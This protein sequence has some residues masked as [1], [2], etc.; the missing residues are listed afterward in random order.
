MRTRE[1]DDA[2]LVVGPRPVVPAA[3]LQ[4]VDCCKAL[5][6]HH[7][8]EREEPAHAMSACIS[9]LHPCQVSKWVMA[10]VP[11]LVPLAA[12][13]EARHRF[14]CVASKS[15]HNVPTGMQVRHWL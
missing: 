13:T 9:L 10:S 14:E 3:S 6:M 4:C 7:V 12:G 2:E 8:C 11:H 1:H 15:Q 5:S